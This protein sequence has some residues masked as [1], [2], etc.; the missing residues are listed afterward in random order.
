MEIELRPK[1]KKY[2]AICHISEAYGECRLSRYSDKCP[3]LTV[4]K[5]NNWCTLFD[6]KIPYTK[7][8]RS[9]AS[10]VGYMHISEII[11]LDECLEKA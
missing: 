3:F 6:K 1:D 4:L 11:R 5:C 7:S 10:G 8:V 9:Y 2:C